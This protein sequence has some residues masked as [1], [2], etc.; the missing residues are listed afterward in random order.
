M[1]IFR[2]KELL[3]NYLSD[4]HSNENSIGFV[5]TMGALHHGHL[6]L[7][8][9]SQQEN[10]VTVVSIFVNPTQF[11]NAEDLEKYPNTLEN[12]LFLLQQIKCDVVFV[13]NASEMYED[14][15]ISEHFDFGGIESQMEGA[16]RKGHFDGVGTIVK[17]FFEI[18]KPT[19]AY[20]GEK[21]FQQLQIIKKLVDIEN[22]PT[23]VIGCPIYR[24]K[25]GLAMS[26]RNKRLTKEQQE[27][28]SLIY[29]TLQLAKENYSNKTISDINDLIQKEFLNHSLLTLEY[30]TIADEKTLESID[31]KDESKSPRAFI[32]AFLNS[33]RLIDNLA[34]Y[35]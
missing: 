6:S 30:F 2:E 31:K 8:S 10:K 21:D 1:Q 24:E 19:K 33:V 15:L 23:Q 29:K 34:L 13:P 25:N 9:S 22:L 35:N 14:G 11:D 7:V 26:S 32:A 20:F 17:R 12:D 18:I 4:F 28:A 27:G 16:F 5:P 3:Q